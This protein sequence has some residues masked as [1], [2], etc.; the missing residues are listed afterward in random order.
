MLSMIGLVYGYR[1]DA[2]RDW[3]CIE[4]AFQH[5]LEREGLSIYPVLFPGQDGSEPVVAAVA[6]PAR[7]K[8]RGRGAPPHRLGGNGAGTTK[9]DAPAESET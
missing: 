5:V 2:Q 4:S 8:K 7:L 6:P 3:P 1:L 9:K